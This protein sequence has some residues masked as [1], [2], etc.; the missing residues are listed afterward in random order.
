MLHR[1]EEVGFA[2]DSRAGKSSIIKVIFN[3]V[4]PFDTR[5][6]DATHELEACE[7]DFKGFFKYQVLDFPGYY[8]VDSLK[9]IEKETLKECGA[10]IYVVDSTV[11]L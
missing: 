2:S 8:D 10:V 11:G 6:L 3:K 9:E 1:A 7:V 4:Q 5:N